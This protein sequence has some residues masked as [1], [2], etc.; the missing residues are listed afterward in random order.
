MEPASFCPLQASQVCHE[1]AH[2][3]SSSSSR[4]SPSAFSKTPRLALRPVAE[5]SGTHHA[6]LKTLQDVCLCMLSCDACHFW[7]SMVIPQVLRSCESSLPSVQETV[8]PSIMPDCSMFYLRGFMAASCS[9]M[10]AL[11]ASS[12]CIF[13]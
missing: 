12:S 3:C 9:A 11:E 10:V 13:C 2:I 5:Q 8:P 7:R 1:Y 4:P 6:L